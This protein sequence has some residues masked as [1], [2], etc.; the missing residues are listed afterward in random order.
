MLYVF[1]DGDASCSNNSFFTDLLQSFQFYFA[2]TVRLFGRIAL[3]TIRKK[4]AWLLWIV[5]IAK[6]QSKA[7]RH[8]LFGPT[9]FDQLVFDMKLLFALKLAILFGFTAL[10]LVGTGL[11]Q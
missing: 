5:P 10:F 2:F 6:Q 9:N 3:M 11:I 7:S 8:R 4:T 1:P